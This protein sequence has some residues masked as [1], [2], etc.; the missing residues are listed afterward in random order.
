MLSVFVDNIAVNL[1]HVCKATQL[2]KFVFFHGQ[3]SV[4]I[5]DIARNS[6]FTGSLKNRDCM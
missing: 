3:D 2:P 1:A 6:T 4:V 5:S